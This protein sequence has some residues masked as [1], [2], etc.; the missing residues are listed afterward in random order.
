MTVA[1]KPVRP[2]RKQG[3][4]TTACICGLEPEN[5]SC[6]VDSTSNVTCAGCGRRAP[7]EWQKARTT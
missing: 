5:P 3:M 2:V 7:V 6:D 4:Y 1:P